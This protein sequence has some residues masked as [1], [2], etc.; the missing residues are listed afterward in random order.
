MFFGEENFQ[1][2]S[3]S[4]VPQVRLPGGEDENNFKE[5]DKERVPV[6]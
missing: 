2:G 3:V 4:G 6:S 5:H 1:C